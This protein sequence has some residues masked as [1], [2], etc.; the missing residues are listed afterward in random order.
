MSDHAKLLR[1]V[2]QALQQDDFPTA[3]T[4]LTILAK[5]ARETEDHAAMARNHG[6]LALVCHRLG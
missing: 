6:N 1:Q 4:A 2:R 5:R 3:L